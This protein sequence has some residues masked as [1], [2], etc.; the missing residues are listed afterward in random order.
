M[1]TQIWFF[2]CVVCSYVVQAMYHNVETLTTKF[3]NVLPIIVSVVYVLFVLSQTSSARQQ[4][5][6]HF[7][8]KPFIVVDGFILRSKC[9]RYFIRNSFI[10]TIFLVTSHTVF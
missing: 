4:H 6:A 2:F 8:L 7:T 9:R 1:L 3:A 5:A 10:F